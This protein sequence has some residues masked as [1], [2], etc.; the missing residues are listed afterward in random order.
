[1]ESSVKAYYRRATY[2]ERRSNVVKLEL[3]VKNKGEH[4]LKACG[5]NLTQVP[6]NEIFKNGEGITRVLVEGGA[7]LGKSIFCVSVTRAWSKDVYFQEYDLLL[8]LPL[9]QQKIASASSVQDLIKK[10]PMKVNSRDVEKYLQKKNG[11][12]VLLVAD[13]WNE[14]DES[15]RQPGSFFYKLLFGDLFSS[16]SVIVTSRPT[17]SALFHRDECTAIH[18]FIEI[19]GFDKENMKNYVQS[20]LAITRH[21]GVDSLLNKMEHNPLLERLCR[22]PLS[23]SVVCKLWHT[24]NRIIDSGVTKL[25]SNVMLN[26]LSS[27][28]QRQMPGN[29]MNISNLA[30]I[31]RLPQ[32]LRE[33]WWQ[34]CEIAFQS[35]SSRS[36]FT[37]QL[38]SNQVGIMMYYGF[39]EFNYTKDEVRSDVSLNFVYPT[40]QEYL[41]ALHFV[42]QPP[43]NQLKSLDT[44][45]VTCK[46]F[47]MFWRY[48]FG[49]SARS[50]V[51]LG[52]VRA[53]VT[54]EPPK[55]I[56][57]QCAFEAK[58]VS[59]TSEVIECLSDKV[60]RETIIRFSGPS[61]QLDYDAMMYIMSNVRNSKCKEIIKMEI[62]FSSCALSVPQIHTLADALASAPKNMTVKDLDLS[63]NNL[64]DE[65]VAHLFTKAASSF[66]SLK[67]LFIAKNNLGESGLTAVIKVLA[68]S[69]SRT[70]TQLDL[71]S[72]SLTLTGLWA[73]NRA[74]KS[75]VL[76]NLKILFMRECF[77]SNVSV[78]AEYFIDLANILLE[79]CVHLRRLDLHGNYLG[80]SATPMVNVVI[81]KL[82]KSLDLIVNREYISEVDNT[83]VGIMEDT[84]K[85]KGTIDHTVVHGV[86][87]GPGR[88][89]KNS[90]MNRLMHQ[91]PFD[92][93]TISPSTG[94]LESVKKVEV[95]KFC[96]VA[97]AVSDLLWRPLDYDEEALELIMVT[98][99]CHTA[100]DEAAPLSTD[101][102]KSKSNDVVE[103]DKSAVKDDK[104][105]YVLTEETDSTETGEQSEIL[106]L[107]E[108]HIVQIT[109]DGERHIAISEDVISSERPLDMF[110]RAVKLRRMDALREHL[111]SSW[112]LYLT[113]TGGQIEFQEHLPLLVCGP[114]VFFVTFPLN[115][116]LDEHYTV[117]YQHKDGSHKQYP[118]PS[119]LMQEILQLLATIAALDCTGPC[120]DINLKPKVFFVGTHRD[121]LP[122]SC[123]HDRIQQIDKQLQDVVRQTSL[124]RQESIEFAIGKEQMI[125]TVNNL[126]KD[127][128][129]FEKIR[130]GLQKAVE[131]GKEFTITCPST[132][133][134]FSLILRAKHESSRVLSYY[135]CLVIAERCGITD[136]ME[137]NKALLFIHSTLGLVRYYCVDK[138]N[139]LVIIDPQ[140]FFD[141]F[142]TLLTEMFTDSNATVNEIEKFKER[143]I[144][145]KKVIERIRCKR[146]APDTK[147]LL[148]LGWLL[149][150]LV[151]L[152]IA[153]RFMIN[154]EE[155]FFFPSTLFNA[156]VKDKFNNIDSI[157][158]EP[159][160][161]QIAFEGGFCP[162]GIPGA[163]IT[164]LMTSADEVTINSRY[165]WE[166]HS[167]RVFKNQVS[168]S[169]G[170][171]D[172]ILKISCTHVEVLFDPES[173][174]SK[175]SDVVTTCEEAFTQLQEAMNTVTKGFRGCKYYFA[176]NCTRH[177]C[178]ERLHPAAIDW[179]IMMVKCKLTERR[180]C[181]PRNY[182]IWFPKGKNTA[183]CVCAGGGGVSPP[184]KAPSFP[185]PPPP[186]P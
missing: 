124:F 174:I 23:C 25:C 146:C 90:L 163:L 159:P 78:T 95:K 33:A 22:I 63:D 46:E 50:K 41:A 141:T 69:S 77:T 127:D 45:K 37:S 167:S 92:Q 165:S 103:D 70:V 157:A 153:A 47:P 168:F 40:S 73:F 71:S 51:L 58:N 186:P 100:S 57:C 13:G 3:M 152:R 10:L 38:S 35:I 67:K 101:M 6:Y 75:G 18:R 2:Q 114:S 53:L 106:R 137:L 121:Q 39:V 20:E 62:N 160:P 110:K 79:H 109:S 1:M 184:P 91:G 26:I 169:V 150:L 31:D 129:D 82:S 151:H 12:G 96:T 112:T 55:C 176:F 97:A 9:G 16:L 118:S 86:I 52:A 56:L 179:S 87:V 49:L 84:V 65:S 145:S 166:L 28:C 76:A 8:C 147:S 158:N 61:S 183:V 178:R 155:C 17:A 32:N 148:P 104:N 123:V 173:G 172:I 116:S 54:V 44:I 5:Q 108:G 122:E 81:K 131:R 64:G 140:I 98:A 136:G 115:Q 111:E 107:T 144:I 171:C 48:L 88:S 185:L 105:M 170:P 154:K 177:E 142:T 149:D 42:K 113:N 93:D 133:L 68:K 30:E 27:N 89:G 11:D 34:L 66:V 83:F 74:I 143:G 99:K 14:L 126:S 128:K 120:S 117:Y 119:T 60:E 139:E 138:L 29:P 15:K 36:I 4:F 59:I 7:G 156:P 102:E 161:L 162:R 182:H 175:P 85:D 94:V 164:Y 181:L 19:C 132:W 24:L 130:L 135:D 180:G 134:I 21:A 80:K 43:V 72:N 125:F